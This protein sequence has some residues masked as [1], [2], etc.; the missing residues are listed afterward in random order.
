MEIKYFRQYSM[1]C[2]NWAALG[3]KNHCFFHNLILNEI[4]WVTVG[5]FFSLYSVAIL[6]LHE[7]V[8]GLRGSRNLFSP[9]EGKPFQIASCYPR[10]GYKEQLTT[11]VKIIHTQPSALELLPWQSI[12][13]T[14]ARDS[15]F[16]LALESLG[17]SQRHQNCIFST[18]SS[19]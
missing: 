11:L 7:Y 12:V 15:L 8:L 6:V 5:Y 3:T 9:L 2:P 10:S 17:C 4:Y 19:E 1:Q 18:L 13:L 14:E 16:P